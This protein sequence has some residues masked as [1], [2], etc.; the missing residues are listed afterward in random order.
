MRRYYFP[1]T[2][3]GGDPKGGFTASPVPSPGCV[4]AR[5][6]NPETETMNALQAALVAW[7][8]DGT[9]PPPSRYPTLAAGDLVA[10]MASA[11]GFP[12]R[13][14]VPP[15][16]GLAVGLM[17]YD[18]GAG[19]RL[20]DFSGV[21]SR[22]PPGLRGTVPALMPRVG[23]D[24]NEMAGVPSVLHQAPLGTY[25]GWNVTS[26]GYFKGQPCGGGLTGGYVPFARTAAERQAAR[27]L[28]PSLEERY[29]TAEGYL[30][31]V[32][33]AVSRGVED[34]VLLAADARRLAGQA[35]QDDPPAGIGATDEA[36]AAARRMCGGAK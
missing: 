14:G 20:N 27:D 13:P 32:R 11:M 2:T 7:V 28:R 4:L 10:N 3:H 8:A 18:F 9:E 15:P 12:T 16:D 22:Q 23:P 36:R 17:D 1:G 19:L 35:A 33:A 5:N 34:R 25:T 29:G 31:A 6:P 24:G 21:I 30:C 26:A